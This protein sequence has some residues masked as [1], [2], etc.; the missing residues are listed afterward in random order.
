MIKDVKSRVCAAVPV[1]RKG[2]DSEDWSVKETLRFLQFLGYTNLVMKTDQEAALKSL[3]SKVRS[4]RGD[5]TQTMHE[6][7][8]VGDLRADGFVERSI[9]S[10]QG[11]IRILRSALKGRIGT[12]IDPTSQIFEWM[13]I[14]AAN[15]M[16]LFEIGRNGRVPYQ[17]L[18]GR[19]LHPE[20]V[21]F[22]ESVL[23]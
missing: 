22:G 7:C 20:L 2:V 13:V 6:M 18:R 19:K 23:H 10:V 9:Q 11:Q 1:P 4:H 16:N 21:E 5:Q 8:P 17:R 14:H 3:M 12:R 15:L